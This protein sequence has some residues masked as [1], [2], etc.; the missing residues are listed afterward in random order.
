MPASSVPPDVCLDRS[1]ASL[2][3][4][5][6]GEFPIVFSTIRRLRRLNR[7]RAA[8]RCLRLALPCLWSCSQPSVGPLRRRSG[9][10]LT[11][12]PHR[13]CDKERLS[14]PRFLDD[15]CVHALLTDP[16]GP[17]ASSATMQLML[18]SAT[19]T[20]SAPHLNLSRLNHTACT[21]PVYAS[22][23]GSLPVHATLGSDGSLALTGSGL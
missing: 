21:P 17:P 12:R 7:R 19:C 5:L 2:G 23:L 18:P 20:A 4:V 15:P 6:S 22:Q 9:R 10:L 3:W 13:V 14:P 1:T 16:G 8:L 11:R